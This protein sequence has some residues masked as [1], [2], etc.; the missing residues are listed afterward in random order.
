MFELFAKWRLELLAVL[1]LLASSG[2]YAAAPVKT[3][4]PVLGASTVATNQSAPVT[5]P[6]VVINPPVAGPT[7]PITPVVVPEP[8]D[9]VTPPKHPPIRRCG[10]CGQHF[11]VQKMTF[12]YCPDYCLQ[13]EL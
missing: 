12:V 9:P 10:V 2:A 5:A 1:T 13:S 8:T 6:K 3:I 4:S 7:P 11:T